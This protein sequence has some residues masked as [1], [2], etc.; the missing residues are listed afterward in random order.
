MKRM[1]GGIVQQTVSLENFALLEILG[2]N[3]QRF[4]RIQERFPDL[5]LVSRGAELLVE[6]APSRI[7]ELERLIFALE[8]IYMRQQTI[9]EH[10]FNRLL[11]ADPAAREEIEAR[12]AQQTGIGGVLVYG[13]SGVRVSPRTAHQRLLVEAERTNDVLFAI[14]PA[15]TG[16]TYI[17]I[18]LAVRALRARS[19]RR[20]ILTRPAVEAGE[21]LGFL[22]G[23]LKD[24]LDPYLQPLYDA[25]NDMMPAATLQSL[26]HEGTIQISPLAYMRG[27]TLD[28][29]YVILDEAQ[30]ATIPQI[31][32]FLTRL[33]RNAKAIVTGDLTQIDL[34]RAH[35]SGLVDTLTIVRDIPGVAVIEM[36]LEDIVRHRLVSDIVEAFREWEAG[37]GESALKE[38]DE[39]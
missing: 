39:A 14:G 32:M 30:N 15:G 35:Q 19:I 26:L 11:L 27:R 20:I 7:A 31:K 36:G 1:G 9:E 33:G 3:N 10:E 6:G 38:E 24:K 25:L 8:A 22:P 4:I 29:A 37:N 21:R 34:P 16:K 28:N 5:R 23:D 13:S 18:A 12:G 2:V 17:A